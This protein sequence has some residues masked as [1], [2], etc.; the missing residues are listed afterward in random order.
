MG[1]E[2]HEIV[3]QIDRRSLVLKRT[4]DE[5]LDDD[6]SHDEHETRS[7]FPGDLTPVGRR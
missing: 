3:K 7:Q 2:Y 6:L 5:Q 4:R 1:K